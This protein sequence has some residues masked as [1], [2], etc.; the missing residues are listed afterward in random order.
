MNGIILAAYLQFKE[1]KQ[2]KFP[3]QRMV[4]TIGRGMSNDL[5]LEDPTISSLHANIVQKENTHAIFDMGSRNGL[6]V[7]GKKCKECVL[8][9]GDE[10]QLGSIYLIY[11]NQRVLDDGDTGLDNLLTSIQTMDFN[12]S[13]KEILQTVTSLK[14]KEVGFQF[15]LSG[16]AAMGKSLNINELINN[17][18]GQ[19]LDLPDM[20]NAWVLEH[21]GKKW[22]LMAGKKE[23]VDLQPQLFTYLNTHEKC[24]FQYQDKAYA[25]FPIKIHVNGSLGA[26]LTNTQ[27]RKFPSQLIM[28]LCFYAAQ[29][30]Q[31]LILQEKTTKKIVKGLVDEN[32]ALKKRLE[33]HTDWVPMDDVTKK[34]ALQ[35]EKMAPSELPIMITGETGVGKSY[36]ARHIHNMSTRRG[37]AFI[38]IDCATIPKDL[39]ESELF[40]HEKGAFTSADKLKAGKAEAAQG[41]TLF[42]DEV[43]ELKPDT[44]AKL[45]RLVQD[46]EYERIGGTEL[47]AANVRI[48]AATNRDLETQVK[49]GKFRKD[50][51]YRL[52]VLHIHLPP[53]KERKNE[54]EYLANFFIKRAAPQED[55]VIPG[56]VMKIMRSHPWP[57]NI[58]QLENAVKRACVLNSE[59]EITLEHLGLKEGYEDET[60]S[61]NTDIT[62]LS[63]ADIR[64]R[65]EKS[66]LK[67]IL[68]KNKGHLSK[69]STQLGIARNTLTALLKKY[70]LDK[71]TI[72]G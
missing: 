11:Y 64:E 8:N 54:I 31:N 71:D 44:Q 60:R 53:L 65:S 43:G 17:L 1:N 23:S 41:G 22:N 12:S 30:W 59:G 14:E 67:E 40:G 57:G 13:K 15:L 19:V 38:T 10:I 48:L 58:R 27:P 6:S 21:T 35:V 3:I 68:A 47:L 72:T 37:K 70:N 5:S 9:H 39:I 61:G 55:I 42:L 28:G 4:T 33:E 62:T 51:Y 34:I 36:V 29:M 26:V 46:N 45:L 49:S 20:G 66:A 7:N 32:T 18:L 52:C 16:I 69:T 56:D 63:L 2:K 50:L 25:S 24:T